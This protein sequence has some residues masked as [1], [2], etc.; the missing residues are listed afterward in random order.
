MIAILGEPVKYPALSTDG[1]HIK[2]QFVPTTEG[3]MSK[4]ELAK[5]LGMSRSNLVLKAHLLGWT[6]PKVTEKPPRGG[7]TDEARKKARQHKEESTSFK[8]KPTPKFDRKLCSRGYE[9][10]I[11]YNACQSSRCYLAGAEQWDNRQST[12]HCFTAPPSL[13]T[14]VALH[15]PTQLGISA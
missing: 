11:H 13:S 7:W 3:F 12:D 14:M 5:K 1:K 2:R 15:Y 9:Q 6:H 10:C 8:L 4:E